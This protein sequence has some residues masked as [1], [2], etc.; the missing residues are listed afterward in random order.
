MVR[1][2]FAPT[3]CRMRI[4]SMSTATPVPLSVAPVA[5]CPLSRCAPIITTSPDGSVP[6]R[7]ANTLKPF[8]PVSSWKRA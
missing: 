6:G 3:T 2:G 7:S 8:A 5:D 1:R 4:A